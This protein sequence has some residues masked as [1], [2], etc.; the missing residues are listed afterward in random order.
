MNEFEVG[1]KIR[2]TYE[3]TIDDHGGIVCDGWYFGANRINGA[4]RI[5]IIES[6]ES[7]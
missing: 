1:A 6:G 7:E 5:E 3:G 2:V 4:T